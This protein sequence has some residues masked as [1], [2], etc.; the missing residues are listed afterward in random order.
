MFSFANYWLESFKPDPGL[1][2]C[3]KNPNVAPKYKNLN[4]SL[5]APN[6]FTNNGFNI[7]GSTNRVDGFGYQTQKGATGKIAGFFQ[8]RPDIHHRRLRKSVH[9][10][11]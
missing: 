3:M 10:E 7:F 8:P 6:L 4:C 9:L 2:T 5:S 11:S 1:D